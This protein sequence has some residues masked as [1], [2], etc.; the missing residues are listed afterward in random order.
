MYRHCI[1]CS[2]DLGTNPALP[3]FPTGRSLAFDPWKGRL[4]V[5]CPRCARW[6]LTPMEERWEACEDAERL[7][8]DARMKAQSENIGLARLSDGTRLIRVGNAVEGEMAAWRY[9]RQLVDRRRRYI[10]GT[11]A[12]GVGVAV[13]TGG[14][15]AAGIGG[16]IGSMYSVANGYWERVQRQR[17]VHRIPSAEGGGP[18][19]VRRWHVQGAP[20]V[21]GDD[22]ELALRIRDIHFEKPS[23]RG[24]RQS[25]RDEEGLIVSG[26]EAREILRRSMPHVNRKGASQDKVEGAIRMLSDAGSID[27]YLRAVAQ[28]GG[29][30]GRRMLKE[31]KGSLSQGPEI[32]PFRLLALEMALNEETERRALE[33]EL[34]LLESAWKAAEEIAAIADVLPFDPLERFRRRREAGAIEAAT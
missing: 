16:F 21:S 18:L 4:W 32:D 34:S 11:A 24:R 14:L 2:A 31:K 17:I 27:R 8:R 1:S 13:A 25:Y 20:L 19:I 3:S 5:I 23:T 30:V 9:G 33:G 12:A 10:I 7:F 29:T 15:V 22:G 28:G 6:N 26:A